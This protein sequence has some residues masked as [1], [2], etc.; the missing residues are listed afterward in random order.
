[1]GSSGLDG[2]G[3]A[4]GPGLGAERRADDRG[5]LLTRIDA[6]MAR[7]RAERPA[8]LLLAGDAALVNELRS[9][10]RWLDRLAGEV[11]GANADAPDKLFRA[12]ALCLEDYLHRRGQQ[13]L[14]A[15]H[16]AAATA[17]EQV[18]AGLDCSPTTT[19]R[20]GRAP[21]CPPSQ[22]SHS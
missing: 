4:S 18:V 9:S 2:S 13:V 16:E 5:D 21:G 6:C 19:R 10:A 17:P 8:P 20:T 22:P 3:P 15:L 11:V 7:L 1:M 14:D 12:T